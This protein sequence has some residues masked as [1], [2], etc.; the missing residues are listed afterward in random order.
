MS[1]PTFGVVTRMQEEEP[2][3]VLGANFST[4]GMAGPAAGA[5][6]S[7]FPLNTPV[8]VRTNQSGLIDR[9]GTQGYMRGSLEAIADQL[10][11]R[12]GA[13]RCIIVRTPDGQGDTPEARLASTIAGI[14]GEASQKTGI[15]AFTRAAALTHFT[16]RI[17]LAPGYT[18][19]TALNDTVG[20]VERTLRGSGYE[21]GASYEL[22]VDGGDP[23]TPMEAHAIGMD[24]GSL[25]QAIVDSVGA[26]YTVAPT[27]TAPA[28]AGG[29]QAAEYRAYLAL[30]ANPV[31]AALPAVCE[32]LAAHAWIESAGI[33]QQND[34]DWRATL[35]SRRLI[36][37]SGGVKVLDPRTAT[38]MSR[39]LAPVAAGMMVRRD[40]EKGAPFHSVANQ[41]AYGIV[42]P[43]REIEFSLLDGE[44]EGQEL[45]SH[46]I[47]ILTRGEADNDNAIASGGFV[48]IATDTASEDELWRMYNVSRG[49]D[50]LHV[51]LIRAYRYFLGRYNITGRLVD[52]LLETMVFALRDLQADGHILG[53]TADFIG[54]KNSEA[55][56][57]QG[58]IVV[59]FRAEEAPVLKR[60]TAESGR[61]R[62]AIDIMIAD[63][64]RQLSIAA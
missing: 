59:S 15:H 58:H 52:A 21:P 39:P 18:G 3:P 4:V 8:L 2:R 12:Q 28:P 5:D 60:I 34:D 56:I 53:G 30:Y 16:P 49:R 9:L 41:P 33:S 10:G 43:G 57:R 54:S 27:V 63:L 36:P 48:F 19:Q 7:A 44:N 11:E 37:I 64:E 31:C 35:Q 29:G 50:Y 22:V 61:Y 45:L 40:H 25:S 14:V 55:E 17:I 47:G 13:A 23:T 62:E 51:T 32:Q 26:G 1:D 20:R 6:P 24:D 42:G 46:N 38:V